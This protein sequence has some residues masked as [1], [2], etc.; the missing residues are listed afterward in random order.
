MLFKTM[1][2]PEGRIDA[3]EV[4]LSLWS[5]QGHENLCPHSVK[6][7]WKGTVHG[8]TRDLA[9]FDNNRH[10]WTIHLDDINPT[11]SLTSPGNLS[12]I[13]SR[14]VTV[15]G[16]A[17]DG[18]GNISSVSMIVDDESAVNLSS[19][20]DLL[21]S[22]TPGWHTIVLEARD[23][24][25]NFA[26]IRIWF[27]VSIGV[28]S[29][30]IDS[31]SDGT[32]T[33]EDHVTLSGETFN[34]SW[35]TLNSAWTLIRSDGTFSKVIALVEGMNPIDIAYGN[36]DLSSTKMILIIK[37]SS[38]PEIEIGD[39]P[40]FVNR[41]NV[42]VR[43]T[44]ADD[45]P[46]LQITVDN[47]DVPI[48][49]DLSFMVDVELEEGLNTFMVRCVDMAG[50]IQNQAV[51]M[52]VDTLAHLELLTEIPHTTMDP[53][54]IVGISVEPN[55]SISV[56]VDNESVVEMLAL[57]GDVFF[58]VPLNRSGPNDIMISAQDRLGNTAE[59]RF[60]V[61]LI[62]GTDEGTSWV[63][64]AILVL[65]TGVVVLLS[66]KFVRGHHKAE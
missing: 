18:Q 52:T 27:K 29:L 62:E 9:S 50:N 31:P 30:S 10:V 6:I 51:Q 48:K 14:K 43:G 39:I 5:F 25:G 40:R 57:G 3:K 47:Q 55:S 58:E 63:L 36:D 4:T 19:D 12:I 7:S 22:V 1:T 8:E 38:P 17:R 13:T 64:I 24:V 54:I 35:L 28:P 20:W 66:W 34:C 53:V 61:E 49:D 56:L 32:I 45:N 11:I 65:I 59:I 44:I 37:D 23:A 21:L 16:M 15:E 26:A 33:R 2:G 41:T 46:P 42:T 60:K